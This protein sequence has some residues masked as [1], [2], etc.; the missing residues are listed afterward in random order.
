[1]NDLFLAYCRSF[2]SRENINGGV[3]QIID[4]YTGDVCTPKIFTDP[5]AVMTVEDHARSPINEDGL[6]PKSLCAAGKAEEI[7]SF[8]FLESLVRFQERGVDPLDLVRRRH[9]PILPVS[10]VL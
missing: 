8:S 6:C 9:G 5:V 10:I 7:A 4:C 3:M 2:A 1:M